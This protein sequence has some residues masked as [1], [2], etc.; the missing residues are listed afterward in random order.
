MKLGI[1]SDYLPELT[2]ILLIIFSAIWFRIRA[3][4]SYG[5]LNRLYAIVI[6]GKEFHD[7]YVTDFWNDRKDIERFNTLFNTRAKSL[8]EVKS[9]IEWIKENNLDIR[10]LAN[11]NSLFNMEKKEVQEG[12]YGLATTSLVVSALFLVIFSMYLI[13]LA[14]SNAALVKF[15]DETQ[16]IWLNHDT[17]YSATLDPRYN[18]GQNWRI[19][20]E[21][22]SQTPLDSKQLAEQTKLKPENILNICE[23]FINEKDIKFV[24]ET[25]NRQKFFFWPALAFLILAFY[26]SNLARKMFSAHQAKIYLKKK[27]GEKSGLKDS[28]KKEMN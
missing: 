3:G 5:L 26:S 23:S 2:F 13:G 12:K 6:G 20:A 15:N 19:T 18:Q 8:Q 22:C 25:I 27:L 16:W 17:A 1:V 7:N 21:T 28:G 4:S 11:L 14:I 10:K 9:F 24:D